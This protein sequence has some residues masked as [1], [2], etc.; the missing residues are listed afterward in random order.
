MHKNDF[1]KFFAGFA[2]NQVLTHGALAVGDV[3]FTLFGIA[4]TPE[5]NAVAA[6]IWAVIASFLVYYAWLRPAR[7]TLA[8]G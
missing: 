6:A 1:A 3:Q 5:F 8:Q 2:A 4:Y 7:T